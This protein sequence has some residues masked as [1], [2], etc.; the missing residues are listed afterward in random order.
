MVVYFK[1]LT[2][3]AQ[4]Y[5]ETHRHCENG[6]NHPYKQENGFD[7]LEKSIKVNDSGELK[8]GGKVFASL[9]VFKSQ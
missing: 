3:G 6:S 8:L 2:I 4:T 7:S 1:G 9:G 5:I